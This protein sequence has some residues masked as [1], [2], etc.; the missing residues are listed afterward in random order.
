MQKTGKNRNTK[1]Q[2]YTNPKVSKL[3]IDYI[4]STIPDIYKLVWVEPSAGNGSFLKNV[5]PEVEKIGVD[6]D[7]KM[8]GIIKADFIMGWL[9]DLA[10]PCLVFGNPPFGRQASLAKKFIKQA[11]LFADAVA[12]ILPRSFLKPSMSNA[13][14]RMFHCKL[15]IELDKNSFEL[16]GEPYDVPCI[17]Q[18]WVKHDTPRILESKV[19]PV[20]FKYTKTDYDIAFRRVGGLAG[21]CCLPGQLNPQ[22]YYFWKLDPEFVPFI[23]EIIKKMN[24][25]IFPSNTVG[26]RS[27]S[28]SEANEVMNQLLKNLS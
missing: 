14:D 6:I 5:P 21:K 13:F 11:C 12:F 9:Y 27:L 26:P 17:F 16:N 20:G 4:I 10:K 19:N 23:S 7:P 22:C 24:E 18:I 2:F 15:T 1:D 8:D 3:C 28:K 25:H